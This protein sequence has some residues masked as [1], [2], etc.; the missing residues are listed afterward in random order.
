MNKVKQYKAGEPISTSIFYMWRCVIALAHADGHM[1]EAEHAYLTR[2]IGNMDRAFGMTAEQ[3]ATF[4]ADLVTPQ[5]M[6]ALLPFI[7]DPA[8]RGQ[9]VYFAWLL[10][11]ADGNLDPREDVILK[12]LRADQ[13]ASLDMEQIRKDVAAAVASEMFQHDL[14]ISA[15]R[16]QTG[17][18]GMLDDIL[19]RA[20][21]DLMY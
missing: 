9:L 13:L 4:A 10:A 6:S 20:G 16:P 5:K 2:I 21:V 15:L 3:R 7:N 14:K 19:L 8:C 11:Y 12:K 17:L 18:S 1:H